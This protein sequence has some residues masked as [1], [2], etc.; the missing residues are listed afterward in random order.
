LLQRADIDAIKRDH[1]IADVVARYG[2]ELRPSGRALVGR[3]VFHDDGG[4]PNMHV[5]PASS[6]FYCFRCAEGGDVLRFVQRIEGVDCMTAVQRLNGAAPT[7]LWKT[8][9]R[10]YLKPR[11]RTYGQAGLGSD[12]RACLA[13]AVELYQNRLLGDPGALGY[14]ASRGIDRATIEECRLGY[15]AGDELVAFL[16]W[17]RISVRAAARVGLLAQGDRETMAGRVTIPEIRAGQPIWMVGRAV[18]PALGQPKYLGL[19]GP[20]PLLGWDTARGS[21]SVFLVEGPFD[22]LVLRS[23]GLPALALGGTQLRARALHA[24]ARLERVYLVLDNDDAGRTA[25]ATIGVAL[26]GRARAVC[27]RGAK[28]AGDLGRLPDG[29]ALFERALKEAECEPSSSLAALAA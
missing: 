9:P 24:L 25:A 21:S 17:R 26:G 22:W 8:A 1:P 29:R 12:E 3:C 20:R 11:T 2:I 19:P 23:W 18:E 4:R 28:D 27:L 16:R 14:L 10:A 6:S 5:Y 13:A 7:R 15:S